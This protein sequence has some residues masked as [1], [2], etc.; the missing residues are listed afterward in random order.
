MV[1]QY[2]DLIER[3]NYNE[4]NKEELELFYLSLSLNAKFREEF[5]DHIKMKYYLLD[6]EYVKVIMFLAKNKL[7]H[8]I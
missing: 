2:N 8:E 3:Y 5:M 1:Q 6:G 7:N 4:L